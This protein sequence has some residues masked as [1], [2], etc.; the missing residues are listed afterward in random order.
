MLV[1]Q[2]Q[3]LS[4]SGVLGRDRDFWTLVK[5]TSHEYGLVKFRK[6]IVRTEMDKVVER[7]Y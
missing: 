4:S 6:W 2:L 7:T 1:T 3:T 5:L